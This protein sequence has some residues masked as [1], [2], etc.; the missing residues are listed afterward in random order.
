MTSLVTSVL[1]WLY[2]GWDYKGVQLWAVSGG[3]SWSFV[4]LAIH[5]RCLA[6]EG[7]SVLLASTRK[8]LSSSTTWH[9]TQ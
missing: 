8:F 7:S 9:F 1:G 2:A 5:H 6:A 3:R 4:S